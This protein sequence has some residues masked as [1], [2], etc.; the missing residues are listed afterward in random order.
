[1]PVSTVWACA[2]LLLCLFCLRPGVCMQVHPALVVNADQTGVQLAPVDNYTYDQKGVKHVKV[3]GA[4]DK[5]Q[6]TAVVA[7]SLDG[8]LL[9]LQ[10]VF[11]GS[12]DRCQPALSPEAA[13][14]HFHFTHSDNHWSN[15]ETM[16]QY[17]E[18]VLV[19]YGERA[20]LKHNLTKDQHMVFVLDCWSVHKSVEFRNFIAKQ[21]KN[22]HLVFIFPNCTSE[23][24]VADV[25][26]QRPFKH[27]LHTRF[28]HWAAEIISEQIETGDH[29]GLSPYLKMSL[30]KPLLASW[31]FEAWSKMAAVEGRQYIKTGW[32][33]CHC[34]FYDMLDN[35][36]RQ[37]VVEEAARG[38]F[39][40]RWV[41]ADKSLPEEKEGEDAWDDVDENE[42]KDELDV[43]KQRQ[44]GSRKSNRK[45]TERL[46]PAMLVSSQIELSDDE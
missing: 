22:I 8:D 43:M 9:P 5:R 4:E 27:G 32:H 34:S 20:A 17:V 16:R 29:I 6:I 40:A 39:A 41:P 26:L 19:P 33:T 37:Q 30:I 21:H 3:I 28:N 10:L 1:M 23:L 42:E 36:K 15:Q 14:A 11:E 18:E 2:H 24:Q 45:R 13:A 7:S 38:E 31:C 44:Y 46:L 12:T 35:T 25:M